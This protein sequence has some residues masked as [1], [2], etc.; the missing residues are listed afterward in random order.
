M[1]LT[2]SY[3]QRVITA[4]DKRFDQKLDQKLKEQ[5]KNIIVEIG[6]FLEKHVLEPVFEIKKDVSGLKKDVFG[7]QMDVGRIERKLDAS[8]ERGDRLSKKLNNQ[9]TRSKK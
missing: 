4:Q 9:E 7:L 3:L 2:K 1:S 8:F 5:Q 6:K